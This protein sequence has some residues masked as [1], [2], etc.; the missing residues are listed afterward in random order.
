MEG[1]IA[2]RYKIIR[3]L[4]SGGFGETFLAQDLQ[5]PSGRQVVI[6]KLKPTN[7]NNISL[8][9]I[10]KLFEKEAKVLEELGQNCLQIPT[11]YA[12][13]RE[14]EDFYLV[15]EYIEGKSLAELG[16][17]NPNQCESILSSLLNTLKYV[18]D[19]PT[20]KSKIMSGDSYLTDT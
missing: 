14:D 19:T 16:I 4:G 7:H 20:D 3:N 9:F 2:S 10:E 17:I 1:A 11:L 18:L 13:F 15:Q 12:Y 6:K 8:E 5:M